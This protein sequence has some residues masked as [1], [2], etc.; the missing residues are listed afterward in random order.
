[1]EQSVTSG[2]LSGKHRAEM[3]GTAHQDFLQTD[4]AVN[5]GNSGGP[6]VDARGRVVGINTAIVGES[7]QGISFAVPSNVAKRVFDDIRQHGRVQRGW[8]GVKMDNV[9]ENLAKKLRLPS[10]NGVHVVEVVDQPSGV[11]PAA[12]AGIQV[13]DVIVSWN[14]KRVK[15]SIALTNLVC[16]TEIGSEATVVLIR[17][18]QELSLTVVVGL[19]P[20]IK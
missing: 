18:G 15:N 10:A 5:P 20:V 11:S 6:L 2:I 8:L 16:D 13:D 19:R 9:D 7:Y 4:A 3:V 14:G 12:E 1:L 17:E